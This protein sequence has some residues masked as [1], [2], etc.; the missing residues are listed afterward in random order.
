M[1][2]PLVLLSG[3]IAFSLF[4]LVDLKPVDASFSETFLDGK[5]VVCLDSA[6][7]KNGW[8]VGELGASTVLG[9]YSSILPDLD[10]IYARKVFDSTYVPATTYT[11]PLLEE[12]CNVMVKKHGATKVGAVDSADYAVVLRLIKF[13]Q[14]LNLQTVLSVD[15]AKSGVTAGYIRIDAKD[16]ISFGGKARFQK[17]FENLKI[18]TIENLEKDYKKSPSAK[19]A[20]A[21]P[22]STEY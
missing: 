2:S 20:E 21:A 17:G 13:H 12:A 16:K 10:G 22:A 6:V 5:R 14:R 8:I 3:F 7:T 4:P 9:L 18:A 11:G 1:S 15:D 19:S